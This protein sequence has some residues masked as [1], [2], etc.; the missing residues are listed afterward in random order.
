[1]NMVH[2]LNYLRGQRALLD[3][4]IEAL[5]KLQYGQASKPSTTCSDHRRGRKH[6][7]ASERTRVSE[8]MKDYW[9]NR[10]RSVV[11]ATELVIADK[12]SL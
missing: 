3:S 9:A 1:M 12:P 5:E 2:I 6:M 8:R 11:A 4:A 7:D 10:R